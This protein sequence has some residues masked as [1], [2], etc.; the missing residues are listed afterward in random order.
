MRSLERLIECPPRWLR[1]L[2]GRGLYRVPQKGDTKEIYITFD[3]GPI[4]EATPWI[5]DT[6]DR[7]GVKAT[8]F[9]VADNARRY[10]HLF[11]EVNR[12]GHRIGNHTFHHIKARNHLP[13]S[14]VRDVKQA[15]R[16]LHS[17]L[18]RPP[19][20]WCSPVKRH[21]LTKLG[22]RIV[23]FDLVTR[24]YSRHTDAARVLENVKR[25]ARPGSI[26]VFHDSLKSIDKLRE[27]LPAAIEWLKSEGYEFRT[28]DGSMDTG[29]KKN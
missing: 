2:M 26:I 17:T 4:P 7:Y 23:M 21:K 29:N 24:D 3:D 6:L 28:L 16:V 11:E 27:A 22:Y 25:Y 19:H 14:Y 9:M 20:G 13:G 10:P 1:N 15:D 5:L 8:F 12:R 18:F